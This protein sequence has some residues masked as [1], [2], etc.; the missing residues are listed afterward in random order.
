[1]RV[2]M[3]EIRADGPFSLFAGVDRVL[4]VLE[5][6]LALAIDG[7]GDFDLAPGSVAAVFPGDAPTTGRVVE[8][9]VLDLNIMARR[10]KASAGL[11][12]LRISGPQPLA[13]APHMRL[14]IAGDGPIGA[15]EHRLVRYDALLLDAAAPDLILSAERPATA[16]LVSFGA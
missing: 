10:G 6:R 5:G 11:E 14:L 7:L 8:G 12:R 13:R 9:P 16:Y 4:V 1:M 2:S 15:S 3:A